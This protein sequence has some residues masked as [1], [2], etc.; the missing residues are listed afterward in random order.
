MTEIEA[1][2]LRARTGLHNAYGVAYNDFTRKYVEKLAEESYNAGRIAGIEES[3][4]VVEARC[5]DRY[6]NNLTPENL[7]VN[8][9]LRAAIEDIAAL[10]SPKET[11]VGASNY[12]DCPEPNIENDRNQPTFGICYRCDRRLSKE[13]NHA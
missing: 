1:V 13:Q 10:L 11:K 8:H 3:K 4:R 7:A 5:P 12:C 9:E 2:K 6:D